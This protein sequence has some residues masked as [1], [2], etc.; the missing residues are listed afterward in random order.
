MITLTLL[1]NAVSFFIEGNILWGIGC[2]LAIVP[3]WAI[4]DLSEKLYQKLYEKK[5]TSEIHVTS[6]T[7]ELSYR[8]NPAE[9]K[10]TEEL[11]NTFSQNL[12]YYLNFR[13]KTSQDLARYLNAPEEKVSRWLNAEEL[14]NGVEQ[15]RITLF[16]KIPLEKLTEEANHNDTVIKE[17]A[18]RKAAFIIYM[19]DHMLPE[20]AKFTE[21]YIELL[22]NQKNGY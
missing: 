10:A 8:F 9:N 7:P 1:L 5:R 3:V 15:D 16:L 13:G 2:C 19:M 18:F 14:P 21:R 6:S 20:D 22:Y 11:Q 17:R 4:Y 12:N